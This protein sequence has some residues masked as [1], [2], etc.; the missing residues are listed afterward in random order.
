MS[1]NENQE[2]WS[3]LAID[4]WLDT[5]DPKKLTFKKMVLVTKHYLSI[6]S[7]NDAAKFMTNHKFTITNENIEIFN[8]MADQYYLIRKEIFNEL[9]LDEYNKSK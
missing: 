8:Q 4:A 5:L 1:T 7:L 9:V 3:N 6:M 2:H